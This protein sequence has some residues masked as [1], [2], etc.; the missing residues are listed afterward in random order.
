M[1]INIF[2]IF[3]C[4]IIQAM[5]KVYAQA[6]FKTI[7]TMFNFINFESPNV[8]DKADWV[9]AY[10]HPFI[11]NTAYVEDFIKFFNMPLAVKPHELR[12][13]D[14]IAREKFLSDL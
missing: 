14:K 9:Y 10:T 8:N 3:V 13:V 7:C 6:D 12:E 1:G 4:L 2:V 5:L 11:K